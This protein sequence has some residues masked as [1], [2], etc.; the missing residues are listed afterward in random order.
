MANHSLSAKKQKVKQVA[1]S[2]FFYVL[3]CSDN[4]LYT[5]ITTDVDRRV[6]EHN[7]KKG[8][9][10]T[11]SRL[12]VSLLYVRKMKDRSTA[13]KLEARFKKLKRTE[14]LSQLCKM[15]EEDNN[16]L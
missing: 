16:I 13:S 6:S 7:K 15:V 5:G 4:S 3:S 14:K 9:K 11:R 10:Y 12:P 8:A 2:W 1:K